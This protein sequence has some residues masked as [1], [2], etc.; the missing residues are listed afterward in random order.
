MAHFC[1]LIISDG[2]IREL[3]TFEPRKWPRLSSSSDEKYIAYDFA[4]ETDGGKF[5]INLLT[6]KGGSEI[7]LVKHP[8]NDK[9]LG[10]VPGRKE[11]LF[12]SDRSGTWD[13]WAIKLD[14]GKP[15]G[16]PERIYADIGD[17]SPVGFTQNGK[18]Y[19]GFVRRNFNSYIAP[20]N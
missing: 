17:V 12:V 11:F 6:M 7:S 18:C 10:W 14:D 20:F 19:F 8:A 16:L 1:S 5:D 2:T 13:L 9:V 3:K 15:T 4:N